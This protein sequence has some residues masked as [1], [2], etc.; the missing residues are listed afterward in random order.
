MKTL[1]N[2]FLFEGIQPKDSDIIGAILIQQ[3]NESEI[4]K[5]FEN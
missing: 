2:N 5:I 4:Q 1:L 3:E